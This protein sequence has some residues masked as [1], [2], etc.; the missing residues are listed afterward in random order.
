[1]SASLNEMKLDWQLRR[2]ADLHL[3]QLYQLLQ[4]R[5]AIFAV[6]QQC[7]YQDLDD[8]DS[9]SLH[10]LAYETHTD[11]LIAYARCLPGGLK[12]QEPSIGRVAVA[13]DFRGKGLGHALIR[14]AIES[15]E[16]LESARPI[17][18]SAQAHLSAFYE[19][20]G[21]VAEGDIYL[22]DGI[23][24]LEMLRQGIAP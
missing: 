16:R 2:F 18:I 24:H 9:K 17:R 1:M 4:M 7:I 10:L 21:F 13:S 12:Y 3:A 20:H 15:V 14:R 11:R 19:Q 22:E 6:E 23:K 5:I 8:L